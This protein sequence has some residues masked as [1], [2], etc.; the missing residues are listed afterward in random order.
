MAIKITMYGKKWRIHIGNSDEKEVW[1][2]ETK[3]GM[4]HTLQYLINLK[5]TNGKISQ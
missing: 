1:E 2:F 5:E 3:E 4:E